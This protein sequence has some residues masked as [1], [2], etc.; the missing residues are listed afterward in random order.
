MKQITSVLATVLVFSAMSAVAEHHEEEGPSFVMHEYWQCAPANMAALQL[1]AKTIWAPIFDELVA[2]GLFLGHGAMVPMGTIQYDSA[3]DTSPEE[4]A[5]GHQWF[6]WFRS[7]SA[8][9]SEAAW[10][11]FDKRL[12]ARHPENP[13]PWLYCDALEIIT[14][15]G[16]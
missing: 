13:R 2:E 12:I 4:G 14:Y 3:D 7:A 11:E 5:P 9:A 10:T 8:E 6:A 15:G 1:T 16:E